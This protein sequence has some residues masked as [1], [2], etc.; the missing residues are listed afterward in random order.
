[1]TQETV[2]EARTNKERN[3]DWRDREIAGRERI[4]L[5][6]GDTGGTEINDMRKRDMDGKDRN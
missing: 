2:N 1:M 4:G 6:G 3:S 5:K